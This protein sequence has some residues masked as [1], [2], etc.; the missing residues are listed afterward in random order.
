L[1]HLTREITLN[2][3]YLSQFLPDHKVFWMTLDHV[4]EIFAKLFS[5]AAEQHRYRSS[6][7][8]NFWSHLSE[9]VPEKPQKNHRNPFHGRIESINSR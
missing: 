7:K 9:K 1:G 2:N 4:F 6:G 8:I 3:D 5:I